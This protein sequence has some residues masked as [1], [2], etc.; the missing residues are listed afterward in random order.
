MEMD[1]SS[2]PR[3]HTPVVE[4]QFWSDDFGEESAY[5]WRKETVRF[6]DKGNRM[7]N[8]SDKIKGKKEQSLELQAMNVG[9]PTVSFWFPL[10]YRFAQIS[11]VLAEKK[12][13][14]LAKKSAVDAILDG[15]IELEV[16]GT[17]RGC[18]CENLQWSK[19]RTDDE[20]LDLISNSDTVLIL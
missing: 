16:S 13:L 9:R 5:I 8:L 18:T 20:L 19:N 15:T 3:P 2:G 4:V 6:P 17:T 12:L 14:R 7:R 10:R 1:N 11:I